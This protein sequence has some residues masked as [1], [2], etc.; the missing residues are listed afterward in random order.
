MSELKVE[1]EAV[2]SV[3]LSAGSCCP[4]DG[5]TTGPT[6]ELKL[7]E[8]NAC[9]KT[10]AGTVVIAINSAD[11]FVTLP[12]MPGQLAGLVVLGTKDAAFTV[13]LTQ[14]DD[15]V[16]EFPL[17]GLFVWEVP[18]TNLVKLIRVKGVGNLA[19]HASGPLGA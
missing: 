17:Q 1:L 6:L 5:I 16:L 4:G 12:M 10:Y 8:K 15:T 14:V 18:T 13:E 9:P 3:T 7:R 11:A 19:W 2:L